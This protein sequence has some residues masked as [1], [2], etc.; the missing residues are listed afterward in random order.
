MPIALKNDGLQE[1]NN[2]MGNIKNEVTHATRN[3]ESVVRILPTHHIYPIV[4]TFS[5]S[6]YRPCRADQLL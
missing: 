1:T 3:C 5:S 6:K 2:A 4:Q